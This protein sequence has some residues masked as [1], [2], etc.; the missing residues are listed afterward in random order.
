LECAASGGALASKESIGATNKSSRAVSCDESQSGGVAAALQISIVAGPPLEFVVRTQLCI[1]YKG[2]SDAPSPH[3]F[4]HT[5]N[6][7]R[8]ATWLGLTKR[9]SGSRHNPQTRKS[10]PRRL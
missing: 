7:I 8:T 6:E 5:P 4:Q 9:H 1:L 10:R 2:V 3:V